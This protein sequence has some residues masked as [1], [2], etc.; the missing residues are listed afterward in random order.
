MSKFEAQ[1]MDTL[2]RENER[3]LKLVKELEGKLAVKAN[4]GV[5]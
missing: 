5:A 2:K 1:E 4:K 3:L